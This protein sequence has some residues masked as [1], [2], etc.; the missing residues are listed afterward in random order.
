MKASKLRDYGIKNLMIV[1]VF[2][3]ILVYILSVL[4]NINLSF[5]LSLIPQLV[6]EGE[7][8]RLFSYVFIPTTSNPIFFIISLMC[9]Y[10][11]GKQLELFWGTFKFN[12]YYF[13]GLI[14]TSLTSMITGMYIFNASALNFS[15][16]LAYAVYCPEQIVYLFYILP[17][18]MKYVAI[19]V[20]TVIGYNVLVSDTWGQRFLE[21]APIFN[22]IL[23]FL[24]VLLKNVRRDTSSRI[25][26]QKF[27]GK[28][29]KFEQAKVSKHRC[30]VCNRTEKDDENLE[31][32]Y[33]SKC[34]GNY[35][36]CSEHI[37]DHVHKE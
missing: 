6:L 28:V 9:Y 37:F 24:P 34:N 2:S 36:Y 31:F 35:E 20:L 18:K 30:V 27:K 4:G 32:R 1:I 17:V 8:W 23:F 11:I 22:F 19:V 29:L 15:L 7:I 33:C 5:K 14:I 12:L 3:N 10:Y 13:S 25:R 21:I 16:F 26:K